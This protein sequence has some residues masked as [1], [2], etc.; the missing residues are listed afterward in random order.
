[1]KR[2]LIETLMGA[3]VLI[4]ALFF[5]VTTYQSSGIK[6][7]Y[8]YKL[9]ALFDKVDGISAGSDVRLSGIK[10]GTVVGQGLDLDS[11]RAKI[12]IG[13]QKDVR[14]PT[15]S[16]AEIVSDGLLGGKYI[17]LVPGA[18]VEMLKD[19]GVIQYTQSSINLEQLIGKVA[20]GSS[21][22]DTKAAPAPKPE[23]K[24]EPTKNETIVTIAKPGET[25]EGKH[26]QVNPAA[27]IETP[28]PTLQLNKTGAAR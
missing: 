16:T 21:G 11:Y 28:K 26:S 14:V 6:K 8:G 9:V 3:V 2:N 18:D 19:G 22:G 23:V 25:P 15:D 12:T 5:V 4:A 20:F 24:A 10:I 27:P 17:S 13:I 7:D 1:M